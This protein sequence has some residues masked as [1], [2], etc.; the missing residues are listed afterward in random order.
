MFQG[1]EKLISEKG[2]VSLDDGDLRHF[3]QAWLRRTLKV[4]PVFCE[5]YHA[6]VVTM[7]SPSPAVR[8]AIRLAEFDLKQALQ[9]ECGVKLVRL[10]IRA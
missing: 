4:Q 9:Q 5:R 8:A 2:S 6:G 7:R 1:L 3:I 10:S